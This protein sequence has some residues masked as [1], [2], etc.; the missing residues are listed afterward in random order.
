MHIIVSDKVTGFHCWPDA[1]ASR[2]YLAH[3]HVHEFLV[4][5]WLDV[6]HADRE[7]E[8]HDVRTKLHRVLKKM[9]AGY[10][11]APEPYLDFGTRSCEQIAIEVLGEMS[12]VSSCEVCE[13]EFGGARVSRSD[14]DEPEQESDCLVVQT[15]LGEMKFP[16]ETE[17][18]DTAMN[19]SLKTGKTIITLCGSMKFKEQFFYEQRQLEECGYCVLTLEFPFPGDPPLTALDKENADWMHKQKIAMSDEILVLNVD[20]YVGS[21]TQSEIRFA[22]ALGKKIT[23]LENSES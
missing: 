5:V 8:F 11:F 4:T 12:E 13:D 22:A 9:G 20:G 15:V 16:K 3:P 17:A 2:G 21:S 18:I 14:L 6:S 19:E 23:Y 10:A 1:P 7:T